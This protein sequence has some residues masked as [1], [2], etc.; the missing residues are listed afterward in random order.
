MMYARKRTNF[1]G[2]CDF[3]WLGST[4]VITRRRRVVLETVFARILTEK[5][6]KWCRRNR[7]KKTHFFV[8]PLLGLLPRGLYLRQTTSYRGTFFTNLPRIEC[9]TNAV[10]FIEIGE[11][12][13]MKWERSG[14]HTLNWVSSHHVP[15][16]SLILQSRISTLRVI[17]HD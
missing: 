3:C 1:S 10:S 7:E 14:G 16:N 9:S 13:C 15:W 4:R 17:K 8:F 12:F 2:R 11:L 5:S 6:Q